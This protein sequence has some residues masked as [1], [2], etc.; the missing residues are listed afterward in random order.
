MAC[1]PL[2]LVG[3]ILLRERPIVRIERRATAGA[4]LLRAQCQRER[5]YDQ[6][7]MRVPDGPATYRLFEAGAG[8]KEAVVEHLFS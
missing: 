5:F 3:D 6:S 2:L 4:T 7:D 8:S 1:G